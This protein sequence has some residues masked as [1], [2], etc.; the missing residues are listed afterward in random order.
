MLSHNPDSVTGEI[1]RRVLCGHFSHV[2]ICTFGSLFLEAHDHGVHEFSIERFGVRGRDNVKIMRLKEEAGGPEIAARAATR[3]HM[4]QTQPFGTFNAIAAILPDAI[5]RIPG[6]AF[7][8]YVVAVAY[9]R[10]G[11][12]IA[13]KRKPPNKATPAD[14]EYS[15]DLRDISDEVLAP[16]LLPADG[17][18]ID[19]DL[20]LTPGQEY[21]VMLAKVAERGLPLTANR[22]RRPNALTL[23]RSGRVEPPAP[24][25]GYG[26]PRRPIPRSSGPAGGGPPPPQLIRRDPDRAGDAAEVDGRVTI[27]TSSSCFS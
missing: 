12:N 17:D 8:S 5:R 15:P 3:A 22:R 21:G 7:C 25:R 14:I 26:T 2:A 13:R 19:G 24:N 10:A 11:R 16:A 4:L 20:R 6:M 9:E 1:I 27:I 18:L 23:Q